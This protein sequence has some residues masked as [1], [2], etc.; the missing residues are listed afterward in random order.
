MATARLIDFAGA[1][2]GPRTARAPYVAP[3]AI[4]PN[5]GGSFNRSAIMRR[6]IHLARMMG[7]HGVGPAFSWR[8]KMSVCLR[9]AWR[10]AVMS[11]ADPFARFDYE[12]GTV[13]VPADR[14]LV[15][16]IR[17]RMQDEASATSG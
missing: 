12:V 16:V 15:A 13:S 3:P 4:F 8:E 14:Q 5:E 9:T 2:R 7:H 1:K 6:A 17:R 11:P 10:Q